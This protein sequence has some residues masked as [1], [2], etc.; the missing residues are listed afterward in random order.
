MFLFFY[1]SLKPTGV[2]LLYWPK[3]N[4]WGAEDQRAAPYIDGIVVAAENEDTIRDAWEEDQVQRKVKED[5]KR[6]KAALTLWRR[7]IVGL[8]IVQRLHE[9]YEDGDGMEEVNPFTAKRFREK[10]KGA[11]HD[12]EGGDGGF[13]DD[14]ASDDGEPGGFTRDS[15]DEDI[16]MSGGGGFLLDVEEDPPD[17]VPVKKNSIPT[18]A[19]S[20]KEMLAQKQRVAQSIFDSEEEPEDAAS[21][22]EAKSSY[23]V[24][25]TPPTTRKKAGKKEPVVVVVVKKPTEPK[26]KNPKRG[27][28]PK[29]GTRSKYF[30]DEPESAP[31]EAFTP[32]RSSRKKG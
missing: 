31:E 29:A 19:M 5:E 16:E 17:K 13:V 1:D 10:G 14:G 26:R 6:E 22:Q 30:V 3:T 27:A 15:G 20:M 25:Q 21:S 8:R 9:V 2:W 12:E 18:Q 4:F 24:G 28:A 32:R 11:A 23:F 7:F